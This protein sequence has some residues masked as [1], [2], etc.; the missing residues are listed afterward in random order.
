MKQLII[1]FLLLTSLAFA[2]TGV[3]KTLTFTAGDSVSA[4]VC[5]TPGSYPV[6]MWTDSLTA[7]SVSIYFKI[8]FSTSW[9]TA[10]ASGSFRTVSIST[11]TTTYSINISKYKYTPLPEAIMRSFI[12][13]Y[14]LG[15]KDE[16]R[17][18]WIKGVLPVKQTIVSKSVNLRLKED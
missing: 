14:P 2:Q 10:P 11:D 15:D 12:Y 13:S 3:N 8:A 5:L 4:A 17:Y 18:V 16:A 9:F 1:T 6:G 7:T